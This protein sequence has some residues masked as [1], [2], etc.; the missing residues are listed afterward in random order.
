[1]TRRA[2]SVQT[3][4]ALAGQAGDDRAADPDRGPG[5]ARRL[6]RRRRGADHDGPLRA[7]RQHP[8]ASAEGD[9]CGIVACALDGNGLELVLGDDSVRG[10][11][12]EGWAGAVVA[13]ARAWGA[14]C[15]VVEKNQGG[16]MATSVLKTA[17]AG[18]PLSPVHARFGKGH[19]A[20]PV[21]ILF[22]TGK[23]RFA[24]A[25]PELEDELCAMVRGGGY[26]GRGSPDRA[27]AMV[28]A[29][30]ELMLGPVRAEPR[31]RRL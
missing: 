16:D 2:A 20:E 6:F 3:G 22:E 23:A 10:L 11:S 5:A 1:M 24:G 4:R 8:P 15:V 29:M 28:H 9:A 12:P 25:F 30:T 19:R 7:S 21:A 18:L 13:A 17:D 26:A 31:V 14:D 27:D